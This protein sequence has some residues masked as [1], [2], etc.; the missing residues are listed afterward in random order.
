[1]LLIIKILQ[2][3]KEYTLLLVLKTMKLFKEQFIGH[4][5]VASASFTGNI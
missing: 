2:I 5:R 4:L 1:M 3:K